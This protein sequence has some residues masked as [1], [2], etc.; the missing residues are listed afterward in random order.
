MDTSLEPRNFI[1][2]EALLGPMGQLFTT[3]TGLDRGVE[4]PVKSS[5]RGGNLK[6]RIMSSSAVRQ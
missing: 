1:H 4:P 5:P 6:E 2:A 3:V